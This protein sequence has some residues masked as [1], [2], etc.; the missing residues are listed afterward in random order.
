M[1]DLKVLASIRGLA[2]GA[3]A[4]LEM[5]QEKERLAAERAEKKYKENLKLFKE[6]MGDLDPIATEKFAQQYDIKQEDIMKLKPE[7]GKN[8]KES[9]EL[10]RLMGM[11]DQGKLEES[12]VA[13]SKDLPTGTKRYFSKELFE[14]P[15]DG[16]PLIPEAADYHGVSRNRKFD[17]EKAADLNARW[18]SQTSIQKKREKPSGGKTEAEKTNTAQIKQLNTAITKLN[19]IYKTP[20]ADDIELGI[21]EPGVL[22]AQE[23][24]KELLAI[25][26]ELAENPKAFKTE[27]E[28]KSIVGKI[29]ALINKKSGKN[30][31][32]ER[33]NKLINFITTDDSSKVK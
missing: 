10:D 20:D 30:D 16:I 14:E 17:P 26:T 6:V 24:K 3:N 9:T 1:S 7:I 18:R 32:D 21:V 4:G 2:T 31:F 29:N 13:F 15:E 22:R 11:Y 19:S 12:D 8:L 28:W 27:K 5:L 33:F 25:S 23:L